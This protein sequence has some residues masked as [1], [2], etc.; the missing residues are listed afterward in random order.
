MTFF[1]T[2]LT[3]ASALVIGHWSLAISPDW[4][5]ATPG[6][7]YAF[8]RDHLPHPGFKTEWW[9]FTGNVHD[10]VGRRFGYQLTFFRQGVRPPEER[11]A[12]ESRFI[13]DDLKFAHFT[14]TDVA[15]GKFHFTQRIS[16]GAFGEAGFASIAPGADPSRLAWIAGWQLSRPEPTTFRL[17]ASDPQ[18]SVRFD[19]SD[20]KPWTIHGADGI[21][22][23]ADGPGHASYY[24]SGTRLPTH[25]ALTVDGRT[26]AVT[27]DTWFDHEWATNQLTPEQ[28]GWDWFSLQ[29][30]DGTELMLYA[31]RTRNGGLD[32]NSSGTFIA[33]DGSTRHLTREEFTLRP[34]A[35]WKSK[36]TGG[37]Y[38]IAWELHIPS[39]A[40]TASISTP[41]ENQE[42]VLTPIAYW[43]GLIDSRGMRGDHAVKGH[44]YLELTGYAGALVGLSASP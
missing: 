39:L 42:L 7:A 30:D 15:S 9:Y 43:E 32:P 28:V 2:F 8:P 25:G 35:T 19:A 11:A 13:V 27:G 21:S 38:P 29:F 41:V 14:V 17:A 40:L 20:G 23:K 3:I 10:P 44:G 18:M 6:H 24:Y 1:R 36:A 31:M 33:A 37:Q 16:R 22:Q 34:L 26:F 4:L 12:G 5:P